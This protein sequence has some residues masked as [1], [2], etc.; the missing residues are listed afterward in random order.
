MKSAVECHKQLKA[1]KPET[2]DCKKVNH[3]LLL[4]SDLI[5]L[6]NGCKRS[7]FAETKSLLSVNEIGGL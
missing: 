4:D 3:Q 2:L 1:I 6:K 7:D 5:T